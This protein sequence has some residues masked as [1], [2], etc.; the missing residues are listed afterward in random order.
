MS[1]LYKVIAKSM[2]AKYIA[3]GVQFLALMIIARW[4]EPKTFGLI[5]SVQVFYA[6]FQLLAEGGLSPAIIGLNKLSAH[7]RDGLFSLSIIMA[8]VFAILFWLA[9]P[10]FIYFY[11]IEQLYL[12]VPF[13]AVGLFFYTC[14]I[15]PIAFLQRQKAFFAISIANIIAEI[16]G[17]ISVYLIKSNGFLL[18]S[19]SFR[20]TIIPLI[21]FLIIYYFSSKTDFGLPR[22]G[23]KF[24]AIKPLLNVTKYQLG[25]SLINYFSRNLDN[26]LVGKFMGMELLGLYDRSYSLMRYPLQLMTSAM[27]PA[28]HPALRSKLDDVNFIRLTYL[29][30]CKKLSFIGAFFAIMMFMNAE[31]IVYIMFGSKWVGVVPIIKL[32][33]LIIPVQV[34][35]S[36]SG[37]IFQLFQR[38]DLMFKCGIFSAITNC[39]GIIIGT[40]LQSLEAICWGFV[41]SFHLNYIQAY[42]LLYMKI[43]KR[44]FLEFLIVTWPVPFS[45]ILMGGMYGI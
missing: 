8:I 22:L 17:L 28:I 31:Y 24:S 19:L 42:Y 35:L 32:L 37:G 34:V 1:M 41:I 25:F 29:D 6:L 11:K 40:Y 43:F 23:S 15:L 30:L 18:Q 10:I 45:V 3:Y 13:M 38:T 16:I 27:A 36:T 20:L 7:D 14:S 39:S 33:S 9:T 21:N 44:N 4:F 2:S 26:I 5:A 12:I